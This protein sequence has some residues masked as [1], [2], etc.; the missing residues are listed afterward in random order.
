MTFDRNTKKVSSY[1][2]DHSHM[3]RIVMGPSTGMENT[4]AN[5]KEVGLSYERMNNPMGAGTV[6]IGNI[7]EMHWS[8]KN[9]NKPG[10]IT[11]TWLF[12]FPRDAEVEEAVYEDEPEK[13]EK[14]SVPDAFASDE[15]NILRMEGIKFYEKPSYWSDLERT[16]IDQNGLKTAEYALAKEGI[17]LP[18]YEAWEIY[19]IDPGN[20]RSYLTGP[21]RSVENMPRERVFVIYDLPYSDERRGV[22]EA[23]RGTFLVDRSGASGYIRHWIMI[24]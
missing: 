24:K 2:T 20:P 18:E 6:L 19:A 21:L 7:G 12:T 17:K 1:D 9:D 10:N 16:A 4:E 3:V 5:I 8:V 11:E 23:R 13:R 22:T 14:I 15:Y